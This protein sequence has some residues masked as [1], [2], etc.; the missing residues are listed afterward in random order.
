EI[1]MERLERGRFRA[2]NAR[3][4][5]LDLGGGET[6]FSPVELLLAAIAGCSALDVDALTSKRAEAVSFR[7]VAGG[8]KIRD[9]Y[10]ANRMID[11]VLDFE[12]AFPDGAEGDAARAVL[13]DAMAKSH[14]RLCTV[15]R[16]V[17]DGTEVGVRDGE[18]RH[19]RDGAWV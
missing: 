17:E 6:D 12:V 13:P 16:T 9:G 3:G 2:T 19:L 18:G 1:S 10:G 8:E 5:T 15:T 7:V 4:A 11:L 14:D